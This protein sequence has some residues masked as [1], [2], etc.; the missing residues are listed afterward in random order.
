M[1]ILTTQEAAD[2][3]GL[4]RQAIGL[5]IRNGTLPAR[6][7]GRDWIIDS[8]NLKRAAKRAKPGRRW[9]A[10]VARIAKRP[11]AGVGGPKRLHAD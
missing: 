6:K 9:P 3:L 5:L 2:A 8:R 7:Q 10:D 11:R 1:A 4:T